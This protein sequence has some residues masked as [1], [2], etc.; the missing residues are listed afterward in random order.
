MREINAKLRIFIGAHRLWLLYFCSKIKNKI[1][2]NLHRINF[3]VHI[4]LK[5]ECQLWQYIQLFLSHLFM[6]DNDSDA[7]TAVRNTLI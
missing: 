2:P 7:I 3:I 1:K 4:K 6:Y 5:M